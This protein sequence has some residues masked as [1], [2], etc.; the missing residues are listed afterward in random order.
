V[1]DVLEVKNKDFALRAAGKK[2]S[3]SIQTDMSSSPLI[4]LSTLQH[5]S[6]LA[7]QI[8]VRS[9]QHVVIQLLLECSLSMN[10]LDLLERRHSV[11]IPFA[12][13]LL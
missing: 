12:T 11:Q 4:Y 1:D 13:A 2:T 9:R 10:R 3:Q 8:L 7:G 5:V 6:V